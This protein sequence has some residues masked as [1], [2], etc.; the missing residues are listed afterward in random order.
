M[1]MYKSHLWIGRLSRVPVFFV[2]LFYINNIKTHIV[3]TYIM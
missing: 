2:K 3:S 1:Y